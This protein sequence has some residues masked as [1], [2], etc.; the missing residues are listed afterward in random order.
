MIARICNGLGSAIARSWATPYTR[1]TS[2]HE[3]KRDAAR[4]VIFVLFRSKRRLSANLG[5]APPYVHGTPY[6]LGSP[7]PPQS[8]SPQHAV[9][10]GWGSISPRVFLSADIM[11]RVGNHA[12]LT[13][14]QKSTMR[15]VV[16]LNGN[17]GRDEQKT[18][19][20]QTGKKRGYPIKK[21]DTDKSASE[22]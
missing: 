10:L 15:Y 2:C 19:Y 17:F 14:I 16:K 12:P 6:K 5:L 9:P 20:C 11:T 7:R 3:K 21:L 4:K 13:P 22:D 8:S 18:M 1:R